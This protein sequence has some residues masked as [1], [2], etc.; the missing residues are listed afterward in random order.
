MKNEKIYFMIT[1]VLIC[2]IIWYINITFLVTNTIQIQS[3]NIQ[4][5]IKIVE[6]T[7]LHGAEFGTE[8]KQIM[9]K[10]E[11]I[12]P[13]FVTITGDMYT[14]ND[15]KGRK[16]AVQLLEQIAK[17]YPTYLVNGEHDNDKDYLKEV[18]ELGVHVLD[19]RKENI[20]IRENEICLYGITNVYY[21]PDFDL[22]DKFEIDERKV[23]YFIST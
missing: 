4:S 8:N 20:Q 22:N 21:T 18:E 3:D 15:K 5:E 1:I 6:L 16:I 10:I 17:K 2:C 12:Q 23:Q 19:N 14:A 13:D 11:K 9:K 7:D